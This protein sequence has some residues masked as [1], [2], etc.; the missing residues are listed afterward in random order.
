MNKMNETKKLKK[1]SDFRFKDFGIVVLLLMSED[2]RNRRDLREKDEFEIF[3]IV[4][5]WS[6]QTILFVI[7]I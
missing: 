5:V 6:L 1:G 2:S 3:E 4:I 7:V